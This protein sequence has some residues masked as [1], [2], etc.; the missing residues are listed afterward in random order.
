MPDGMLPQHQINVITDM[1][2][3]PAQILTPSYPQ[4][5]QPKAVVEL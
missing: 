1:K 2:T 3:V 4:R 5:K